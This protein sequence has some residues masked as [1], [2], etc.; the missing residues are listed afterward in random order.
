M[1]Y[2]ASAQSIFGD[3]IYLGGGIGSEGIVIN[4]FNIRVSANGQ[5]GYKLTQQLST[6]LNARYIYDK[7]RF[8]DVLL[9]H[10]GGGPFV[11]YVI[12]RSLFVSAEYERMTYQVAIANDPN[13]TNRIGFNSAFVGGGYFQKLNRNAALVLTGYYNLLYGDG[14][15]SQYSSPFLIRAGFNVGF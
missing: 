11:R 5:I 1:A 12:T 14:T 4:N 9:N 6:G 10:F 7:Y 15:N 8:Q 3:K 2:Q 13:N